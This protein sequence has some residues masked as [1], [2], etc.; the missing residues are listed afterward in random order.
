M[1]DALYVEFKSSD[2]K[3]DSRDA[4]QHKDTVEV[5][6]LGAH[7]APAEVGNRCVS[8]VATPPSVSNMAK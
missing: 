5:Q 8:P 3:G 7:H 4:K 1:K 2:I 6:Q